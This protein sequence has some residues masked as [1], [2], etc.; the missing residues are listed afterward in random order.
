MVSADRNGL[1]AEGEPSG[2]LIAERSPSGIHEDRTPSSSR[3]LRRTSE[4]S[5]NLSSNR[6]K[7]GDNRLYPSI[8]VTSTA[9]NSKEKEQELITPVKARTT[10][11]FRMG[12]PFNKISPQKENE[13]ARF[14]RTASSSRKYNDSGQI[15]L[16]SD[17]DELDNESD[18][19]GTLGKDRSIE[20]LLTSN[21]SSIQQS[22]G[23]ASKP[24]S[25]LLQVHRTSPPEASLTEYDS[26][27]IRKS[28]LTE[29]NALVVMP[30]V[31]KGGA[32]GSAGSS[33]KSLIPA[34]LMSR[35]PSSNKGPES[36]ART[37]TAIS[38]HGKT[39]IVDEG[40]ANFSEG[41]SR[42]SNMHSSY[43]T[44][45][46]MQSTD[47]S[48]VDNTPP[49]RGSQPIPVLTE[50]RFS[51][52]PSHGV[53]KKRKSLAE[54]GVIRAEPRPAKRFKIRSSLDFSREER[55]VED[56]VV[57]AHKK[58]EEFFRNHSTTIILSTKHMKVARSRRE[59]AAGKT[60]S[61]L[62][63]LSE[64]RLGC[65][66]ETNSPQPDESSDSSG[67]SEA[68][69][70]A[71]AA[72]WLKHPL[73]RPISTSSSQQ[74]HSSLDPHISS[75]SM[76]RPIELG[77]EHS[78]QGTTSTPMLTAPLTPE[79]PVSI[80]NTFTDTYPNYAGNLQLFV[81]ACAL[82]EVL[83]EEHR[84]EHRALWD[85]FIFLYATHA[86]QHGGK[87]DDIPYEAWF[88]ENVD[89][90]VCGKGVLNPDNLLDALQL[91]PASAGDMRYS[92]KR[93]F[94][95]LTRHQSVR[96][97][98][99]YPSGNPI[100]RKR[101]LS[102]S[103]FCVEE[104]RPPP[105]LRKS[106]PLVSTFI[107]NP[108]TTKS[109]LTHQSPP[110]VN[111]PARQRKTCKPP[112]HPDI[113]LVDVPIEHKSSPDVTTAAAP[114]API[115]TSPAQS[116]SD[117]DSDVKIPSERSPSLILSPPQSRP[118]RR[119]T[120][121]AFAQRA[122]SPVAA[123]PSMPDSKDRGTTTSE[124]L[125][126]HPT[127]KKKRTAGNAFAQKDSPRAVVQFSRLDAEDTADA[128]RAPS[129]QTRPDTRISVNASTT[130]QGSA[131]KATVQPTKLDPRDDAR[132][133]IKLP[134]GQ[135]R[136]N[137]GMSATSR[138]AQRASSQASSV[139]ASTPASKSSGRPASRQGRG[140]KGRAEKSP[141]VKVEGEDG[142]AAGEPVKWWM[143]RN[144][145][146]KQFIR[147]YVA[148]KSVG[149]ELGRVDE[150]TGGLVP[151]QRRLDVLGWKL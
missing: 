34:T 44:G 127:P 134:S 137:A 6:F 46:S 75:R 87:C 122:D 49:V 60:S 12:R 97:E 82:I 140:K 22:P 84:M 50:P 14:N 151:V 4:G 18:L 63:K 45:L 139:Q 105:N 36:M 118:S 62:S 1:R 48:P 42:R 38:S 133:S 130:Q 10:S 28:S 94:R 77:M 114:Q 11:N 30:P 53:T 90:C 115:F 33:G 117:T 131:S 92:I 57:L 119:S 96:S 9:R 126:P 43:S 3:N 148:L 135:T 101:S 35:V 83:V 27:R 128:I 71:R 132:T 54:N 68:R 24:S 58:R 2:S 99:S 93:R 138:L 15:D 21:R 67:N 120:G 73:L 40:Q 116:D 124:V 89:Y 56:P 66:Q 41:I 150:E 86:E 8:N 47:K 23:S 100:S 136:P 144:T 145:P 65:T 146:L 112:V 142:A 91:D 37:D 111:T 143:E 52:M 108:R 5:Q 110:S 26:R 106:A 13:T 125:S 20:R 55:Q 78:R 74:G 31:N 88:R 123:Q 149:G 129:S 98:T 107:T 85:D 121:N 103:A 80:Y 16:P 19:L 81:R 95:E 17:T 25:G 69:A 141:R 64:P 29:A 70:E 51:G 39:S 79:L 7:N 109:V 72:T 147:N 32:A 76:P 61:P 102:R 113:G 59:V 104:R